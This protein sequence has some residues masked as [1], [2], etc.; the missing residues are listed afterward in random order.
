M[1]DGNIEFLGRIDNQVKIRGFRIEL[2]EIRRCWVNIPLS[3]RRLYSQEK[4]LPEI[5]GWRPTSWLLMALPFRRNDLRSYLQHKLPDYMVPSAFVFLESLP[6]TPNGKLDRKALP[7]PDHSRPELDDAFAAPRTPGEEMLASIWCTVLKLDNVG[8]HDN[9][10]DL[11][12]HSLLATQIVSRIHSAF[13][14]EL[15]LR[16]LFES[17]T[18][19]EMA[20]II[21]QTQAKPAPAAALAQ[22]LREV[23]AMTDEEAEKQITKSS[24][25]N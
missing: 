2:G 17:P 24:M 3:N 21:A 4:I 18:V 25:E 11:G 8:I 19:A 10:F 7:V 6:V 9:F 1:A 13:S 14:I 23:E 16:R 20:I 12:G 22:M 15:P 5:I